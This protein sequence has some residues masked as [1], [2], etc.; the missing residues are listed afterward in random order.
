MGPG[1]NRGVSIRYCGRQCYGGVVKELEVLDV[2]AYCAQM[3]VGKA[4]SD[5]LIQ[6]FCFI[7]GA[8]LQVSDS[9]FIGATLHQRR[10]SAGD[11]GKR[12]TLTGQQLQTATVLNM[13]LLLL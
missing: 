12:N 9:Q 3:C 2:I 4:L 10:V 8:L 13:E 1:E 11:D 6:S 5:Q 7:V